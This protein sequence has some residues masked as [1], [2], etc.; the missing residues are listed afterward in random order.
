M[1]PLFPGATLV[2]PVSHAH[3]NDE[4]QQDSQRNTSQYNAREWQG[5]RGQMP[6]LVEA[7]ELIGGDVSSKPATR[8]SLSR[9]A[10]MPRLYNASL[11]SCPHLSLPSVAVQRQGRHG[12]IHRAMQGGCGDGRGY[13][14][15]LEQLHKNTYYEHYPNQFDCGQCKRAAPARVAL[16]MLPKRGRQGPRG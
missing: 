8:E 4:G 15:H 2:R 5:V 16:P 1:Y 12:T 9:V 11:V 14:C 13:L 10:W 7:R 6:V 3:D